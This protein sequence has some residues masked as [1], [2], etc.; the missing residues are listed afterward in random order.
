MAEIRIILGT[1]IITAQLADNSASRDFL[2]LLPLQ[3]ELN[4]YASTEKVADLPKQLAV[5]DT[6]AGFEPSAG[7]IAYYAPWGNL[8]I[9]YRDFGYANRLV[10][11]GRITE[12]LAYLNFRGP[13]HATIER[14]A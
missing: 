11:L 14:V 7:D 5:T 4:D 3:L 9:F 12:G 6:P 13:Q 8:A 10:N 1:N 2:S